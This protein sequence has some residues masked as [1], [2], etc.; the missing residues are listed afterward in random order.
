MEEEPSN[1][2]KE[3]VDSFAALE[4]EG[5]GCCVVEDDENENPMSLH[6]T[7]EMEF[8]SEQDARNFYNVY[9]KQ[10]GFSIRVNS[11][12]R[13]KK[14]NSIISRESC[15]SK[16]GF[17]REKRSRNV[18]SGDDTKRRRARPLTR[19]GCKALMTV[20]RRNNGKWC[21]A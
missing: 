17:H 14:D 11:Y 10:T 7:L 15:C 16:E 20:R 9:A 19:E 6:N 3:M 12:Y 8:T 5:A 4:D 2:G 1:E 21:V 13:S 18:D